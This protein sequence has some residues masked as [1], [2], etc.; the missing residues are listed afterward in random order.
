MRNPFGYYRRKRVIVERA[1]R[2]NLQHRL[3]EADRRDKESQKRWE[4]RL[5]WGRAYDSRV[6][7]ALDL[8][9]RAEYPGD[10]IEQIADA[11]ANTIEWRIGR[12]EAGAEGWSSAPGR[13]ASRAWVRLLFDENGEP[14]G[15]L[16]WSERRGELQ[17]GLE[18]AS[19]RQALRR[20]HL[21]ANIHGAARENGKPSRIPAV[22]STGLNR[23]LQDCAREIQASI[24]GEVRLDPV[25][26]LLYSTDASIYQIE[27]LGVVFPRS[28]AELAAAVRIAS[29]YGVPVLARGAGSSLAG[30]AIGPALILDCSRYL[31]RI[32]AIHP[33]TR[34]AMVEPGVVLSQLN[35]ELSRYGL[36]FGPD[37]ASAERAT[38]GGSIANNASGSHSILYGMAADHLLSAQVVLADGSQAFFSAISIEEARRRA[39][40]E[41]PPDPRGLPY[42]SEHK[43]EADIYRAACMIREAYG[44]EIRRSWPRTW[45][46]ASGYNLNYLLPWS[47][48]RPPF[49]GPE[50]GVAR[51]GYAGSGEYPPV[52]PGCLNLAPL[53][54]GSEGTLAVMSQLTL[55]LVPLPKQTILAVL[56]YA[57][58]AAACAAV[59]EILK[60]TQPSAVELIP[61]T[62]VKR[63]REIPAYARMAGFWDQ[64]RQEGEPEA[65]L[66]VEFSGEDLDALRVRADRLRPRGYVAV[67]KEEQEQVWRVRKAGLG[68]LL[69]RP[70]DEKPAAFIEDLAVPVERLDE[71]V[72]GM[73]SLL[74]KNGSSADLYAHASAGCLHIRPLLNLKDGE[75]VRRMREIAAE[76]VELTLNLAGTV[77]GEHGDGIA[78]SQWLEK[79][80][81]AELLQAFRQLKQAA[82]PQGL[83]NPGKI[84]DAPAMHSNLRYGETYQTQEWTT[85]LDFSPEGGLSGAVEQCNGAGVCRKD[86]GVMCP[87]FQ[88][89]REEMH[90]TRGRANLLRAMLSGNFPAGMQDEKAVYQ[91]MDLCLACKGCRAEC[92]SGVDMAKLKYE[93]MAQYYSHHRRPLRDFLFAYIHRLAGWGSPLASLLNPLMNS[94][95]AGSLFRRFLGLAAA[96]PFPQFQRESLFELAGREGKGQ[97]AAGGREKALFLADAFSVYFY[98]GQGLASLR[99]LERAQ[100]Q[101]SLLRTIGAGRTL[102]SKGFLDAARRHARELVDEIYRLDPGGTLPVIGIEPSEILTLRDEYRALL[103]GDARVEGL[104]KRAWMLDEYLLRQGRDGK[105]RIEALLPARKVSSI[106]FPAAPQPP[107]P[108]VYLHAHCYQKAQPPCE[109]GEPSG[110]QAT[111]RMLETAG[112]RVELIDSGCCGVAGA[113]GYET[114]HY[115]LS[116]KVGEKLLETVRTALPGAEIAASGVS[117]KAQIED[118][119]GRQTS[120]PVELVERATR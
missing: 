71:F 78:R 93:F 98:P 80:F 27:P 43:L 3:Q 8:V 58:V 13:F 33:E 62:L 90:S 74:R 16:C 34:T 61:R 83:L 63:A 110:V 84:L 9:Q 56:P 29:A 60:E 86:G 23:I 64:L 68:L 99:L 117:C 72:S 109:D 76:A 57:S 54:A 28:Q 112:Y 113:F 47:P 7:S 106:Q 18:A 67:A 45:R 95:F 52:S 53:L 38:V 2:R 79:M 111:I 105:R 21:P 103:P 49:W 50:T 26:R 4:R 41:E 96:R 82:D 116:L 20:L 70:G 25:S 102:I 114:E 51:Y 120:H 15:F 66:A 115:E 24:Q 5:E 42:A 48:G 81:G 91:A 88:A 119:A 37:P 12:W 39:G 19:L 101:V 59:P 31:N 75:G 118:G 30:Q 32:V 69:S 1:A 73:E 46:S 89:T 36:Q 65:L 10:E 6:I 11:A 14:S 35:R 55:N 44:D 104:A 87:S 77:S 107:K 100:V 92:P 108:L 97:L 22:T 40:L 94:R 17:S 85:R